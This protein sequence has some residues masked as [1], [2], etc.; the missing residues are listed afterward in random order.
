M[1]WKK[2]NVGV[3]TVMLQKIMSC[4]R[5]ILRALTVFLTYQLVIVTCF[6]NTRRYYFYISL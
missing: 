4:Q 6:Y 5:L 1:M 2:N 3:C